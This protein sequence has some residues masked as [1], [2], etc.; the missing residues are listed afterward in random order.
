MAV[1]Y[2]SAEYNPQTRL[3][4]I[5]GATDILSVAGVNP[6]DIAPVE[7]KNVRGEVTV[8]IQASDDPLGTEMSFI[9][10]GGYGEWPDD[11]TWNWYVETSSL[12][13]CTV[14]NP[15]QNTFL[16]ATTAPLVLRGYT[17]VFNPRI[18]Y[19][20]TIQRTSGVPLGVSNVI[21]SLQ[22]VNRGGSAGANY[23]VKKP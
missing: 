3:R 14:T 17:M 11:Y 1:S 6:I 15:V 4:T 21:V 16:I 7:L 12:K 8:V 19:A 13:W 2:M 9:I 20:P 18:P 23:T 10:K 5:S 22:K